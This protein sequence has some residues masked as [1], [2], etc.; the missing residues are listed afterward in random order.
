MPYSPAI[1]MW[2]FG[3]IMAEL[4]SGYPIYPGEN[5]QEQIGYMIELKGLPPMELLERGSRS[6]LFFEED[7]RAIPVPNSRGKVRKPNSKNFRQVLG[8]N[9]KTFLDF[10]KCCFEWIPEKRMTPD[11]ALCHDW[12]LEGLPAKI[13]VHHQRLHGIPTEKL[14]PSARKKV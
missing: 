5:E 13:L 11:E 4:F 3:C 1:D 6:K 2:S 14:P 9:D 7:G 12:I 10:L 8:C